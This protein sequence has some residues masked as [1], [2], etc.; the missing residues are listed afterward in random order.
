MMK[1]NKTLSIPKH[2][3]Q[4]AKIIAIKRNHSLSGLLT[5]M[6]TEL[7]ESEERYEEAMHRNLARLDEARALNGKYTWSRELLHER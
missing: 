7:V 2:V 3:L 6:L 4:Q 5:D 1:Q